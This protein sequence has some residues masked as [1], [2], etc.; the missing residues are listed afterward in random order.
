MKK[1]STYKYNPIQYTRKIIFYGIIFLIPVLLY[2][3]FQFSLAKFY[4]TTYLLNIL[5]LGI[6]ASAATYVTWNYALSILGAMRTSKLGT[7]HE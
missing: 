5:Y 3:N 1:I 4:S 6:G 2:T 7:V